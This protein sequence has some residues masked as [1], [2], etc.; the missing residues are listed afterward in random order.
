[1][2]CPDS[3]FIRSLMALT[4]MDDK[5]YIGV[6]YGVRVY[7]QTKDEVKI[8]QINK[9]LQEATDALLKS[10]ETPTN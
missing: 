9:Y 10:E 8:K 1:L 4:S 7:L 5:T 6:I 3:V 2:A